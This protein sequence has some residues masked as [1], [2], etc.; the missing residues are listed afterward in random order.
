MVISF[1]Q[2]LQESVK[3]LLPG[4]EK[5]V[6]E[7]PSL[8]IGALVATV[9]LKGIIGIGCIRVKTT[10]VQ[11]LYQGQTICV[12]LLTCNSLT[13]PLDCKTDVIFNAA[14]LLFPFIGSAANI[15]WLDPVGAGLLS[16]F[17]IY[18]WSATCFE[19]VTRLSGTAVD[20]DME[21]KLTYLAWRFSPLVDGFK[22]LKAYHA[23]D[24]VWVEMDLLFQENTLLSRAHDVAETLQYC[25]EG[26][27]D[28]FERK[29]KR[30]STECCIGL[31]EVDRAFVM[32]DCTSHPCPSNLSL[33][34]ISA[35]IAHTDTYQ[36]PS[37]H[38]AT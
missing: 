23:G 33:S 10:Q 18:D 24:G 27:R 31:D 20:E 19:N 2:I 9:V 13:F 22:S 14:S 6:T 26:K 7:L 34:I 3:K 37:G 11:A 1:I 35:D 36:G 17:I 29:T 12:V 16:L 15:W 21:K 28:A 25:C 5:D 4:G 32:V 8:A 38:T 30:Q